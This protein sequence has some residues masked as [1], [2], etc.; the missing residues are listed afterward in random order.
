MP[1]DDASEAGA[2]NGEESEDGA[3]ERHYRKSDE[4]EPLDEEDFVVDDV[5]AEDAHGVV[6]VKVARQCAGGKLAPF[7]KWSR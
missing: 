7:I 5:E 4:P 2:R 1:Y 6:D 3:D